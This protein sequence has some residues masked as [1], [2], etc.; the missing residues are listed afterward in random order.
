MKKGAIFLVEAHVRE[1]VRDA[2]RAF[3]LKLGCVQQLLVLRGGHG[4]SDR[5]LISLTPSLC[6]IPLFLWVLRQAT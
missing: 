1:A 2:C 4:V 3:V 6:F 5:F